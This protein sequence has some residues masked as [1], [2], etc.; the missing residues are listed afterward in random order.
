MPGDW[1]GFPPIAVAIDLFPEVGA[2]LQAMRVDDRR[3]HQIGDGK[4]R[5]VRISVHDE[6]GRAS[7]RN[8]E[9][10]EACNRGRQTYGGT[11]P[12]GPRLCAI[13]APCAGC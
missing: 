2:P 12:R 1:R 10:A 5:C 4:V 9:P 8:A 13:V 3:R 6:W 11:E 7:P